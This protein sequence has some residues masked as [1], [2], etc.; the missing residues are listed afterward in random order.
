MNCLILEPLRYHNFLN[1]NDA[2]ESNV[3]SGFLLSG[4]KLL[5]TLIMLHLL[6]YVLHLLLVLIT[7]SPLLLPSY[8]T[9][10]VYNKMLYAIENPEEVQK[11]VVILEK[12]RK[13]RICISSFLCHLLPMF[14]FKLFAI[15][16]LQG[17]ISNR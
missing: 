6:C 1:K 5:M 3:N 12:W 10:L 11:S 4:N 7:G 2:W 8:Y 17:S 15:I 13:Y 14:L 16:E 9:P